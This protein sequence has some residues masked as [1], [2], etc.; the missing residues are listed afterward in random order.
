MLISRMAVITD[1]KGRIVYRTKKDQID[2]EDY[3]TEYIDTFVNP[4]KILLHD[5]SIEGDPIY[6]FGTSGRI[7]RAKI[8][9]SPLEEISGG[10]LELKE[11]EPTQQ[12]L[13]ILFS[14]GS[15]R[16]LFNLKSY[17]LKVLSKSESHKGHKLQL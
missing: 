8:K 16:K 2:V 5:I 1:I 7:M 17:I 10:I 6:I 4:G 15:G 13:S 11:D 12:T 14:I 3:I 9:Y